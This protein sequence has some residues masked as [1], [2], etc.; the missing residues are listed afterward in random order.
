M[1]SNSLLAWFFS[2]IDI[3]LCLQVKVALQYMRRVIQKK[4]KFDIM[5][6]NCVQVLIIDVILG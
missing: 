6:L 2:S 5:N 1:E 4:A 3:S